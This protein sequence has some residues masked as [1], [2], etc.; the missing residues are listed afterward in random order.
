MTILPRLLAILG[1]ALIFSLLEAAGVPL[2]AEQQA[3]FTS[4]LTTAITGSGVLVFLGSYAGLHRLASRLLNPA[5]VAAPP[6][7]I[8]EP[9]VHR[10]PVPTSRTN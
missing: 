8:A 6:K 9:E 4:W 7:D 2:T 10:T 1:A 5:D 3:Q